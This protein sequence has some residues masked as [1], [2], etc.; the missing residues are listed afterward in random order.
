MASLRVCEGLYV[1]RL[2]YVK[3][4]WTGEERMAN[5]SLACARRGRET[6]GEGEGREARKGDRVWMIGDGQTTR[7][8]LG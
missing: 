7:A 5:E 8:G 2:V 6:M 4:I 1:T 3:G